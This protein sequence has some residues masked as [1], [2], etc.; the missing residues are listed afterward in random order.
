MRVPNLP[1][2]RRLSRLCPNPLPESLGRCHQRKLVEMNAGKRKYL[3]LDP[4]A[5][6]TSLALA[7]TYIGEQDGRGT[8]MTGEDVG[9]GRMGMLTW[10]SGKAPPP[11]WHR[12]HF[13]KRARLAPRCRDGENEFGVSLGTF[14]NG[15]KAWLKLAH[16][17]L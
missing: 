13:L 3:L 4:R 5:A 8:S 2:C 15:F 6:R 16:S 11:Q 14:I 10:Y 12:C 7:S 17:H 9:T 1:S